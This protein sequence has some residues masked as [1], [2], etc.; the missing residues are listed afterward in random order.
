MPPRWS[1][2]TTA[3]T[4]S[5]SI[6]TNRAALAVI[7]WELSTLGH[8]LSDLAYTCMLYDVDA[9][10]D[11]R[12]CGRRFREERDPG[13]KPPSSTATARL[14]RPRRRSRPQLLQGL[15]TVSSPPPSRRVST[16]EASTEMRAPR[17]P[18]CLAPRFRTSRGSRA[19][20]SESDEL[21]DSTYRRLQA[22][23]P[24]SQRR[25]AR[26]VRRTNAQGISGRSIKFEA[27][28]SACPPTR[29]AW[30]SWDIA[31]TLQFDSLDDVRR[32]TSSIQTTAPTSTTT[33]APR[34][35]F[36]QR[37]ELQDLTSRKR[38]QT[39]FPKGLIPEKGVR[40]LFPGVNSR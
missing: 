18:R 25:R 13:R 21:H 11:R 9:S 33:Q 34:S 30:T 23:G 19:T 10:Q 17:R 3:S 40:P 1:M 6:Q 26:R 28:P 8:P 27:S 32:R 22:Q 37:L 36:A 29:R 7:D 16:N 5:S 15:F 39:P 14:S 24:L 38:G 12:S 20:L 4:I 31:I 2:A 35:S